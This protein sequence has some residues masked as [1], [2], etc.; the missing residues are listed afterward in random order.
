MSCRHE[1]SNH[2][3]DVFFLTEAKPILNLKLNDPF[4]FHD[5]HRRQ[6]KNKLSMAGL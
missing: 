5:L 6:D 1:K 3:F 2:L 4:H